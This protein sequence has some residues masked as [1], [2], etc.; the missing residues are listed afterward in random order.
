MVTEHVPHPNICRVLQKTTCCFFMVYLSSPKLK[1]VNYMYHYHLKRHVT[2]GTKQSKFL[3]TVTEHVPHLYICRVLQK[4]TCCFFMVYLS[5][6]KLK[7]VNCMYN[8]H[9]KCCV[10][11]GTKEAKFLG[12]VT[13]S[14]SHIQMY[15]G[16]CKRPLIAN[17]GVYTELHPPPPP[18]NDGDQTVTMPW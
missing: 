10:T 16:Y 12:M 11:R 7:T 2:R 3:G 18:N 14:I 5:S 6:L 13:E 9:H 1:T 4:T 17:S 15:V 8:F